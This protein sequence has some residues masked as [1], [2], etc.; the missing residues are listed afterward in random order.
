[1]LGTT[2]G[3]STDPGHPSNEKGPRSPRAQGSFCAV[4]YLKSMLSHPSTPICRG[5]V[6]CDLL[7]L[8]VQKVGRVSL[9]KLHTTCPDKLKQCWLVKKCRTES[10]KLNDGK[11][12]RDGNQ[13]RAWRSQLLENLCSR[14]GTGCSR[15]RA[16]PTWR[17]GCTQ[18]ISCC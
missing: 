15:R 17:D 13:L 10:G 18:Q 7:H 2:G 3:T 14:P 11:K 4:T 5:L 16:A 6:A 1:M 8:Y 9:S 12:L